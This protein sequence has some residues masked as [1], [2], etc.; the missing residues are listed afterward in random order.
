MGVRSELFDDDYLYFYSDVLGPQ[1]S[2]ADAALISELLSLRPG[3]RLLDA[4]CGE[5]RISGRLAALGCEVVG[6]D[7]SERFLA[8]ARHRHP[9][10]TFE[11]RDIRELG[12]EGEFDAAVNW[13]TSFGYF[14]PP[15]NDDVLAALA[16]GL[17]PGG[18]L[19]LE[20]H[21][22]WR[23]LRL[24]AVAG[25][26]AGIVVNRD[27]NVIADRIS[28]DEATRRSLTVALH[29]S[30]GRVRELEFSLEQVPA[31]ELVRRLRR[32]GFEHVD[33]RGDGGATFDPDS[34]R[35]IAI[36]Q[37]PGP[38]VAPERPVVSLR[39]VDAANVRAVCE[40][41]LAPGQSTYVAPAAY[42]LAEAQ[43]DE[44]AWVRVIY[45]GGEVVGLLA[46]I[47]DTDPPS[48]WLARLLVG[49]QHQHRGFGRAAIALL[50]E[51]VRSLPGARELE[52]SCVPGL[53]TPKGFYIGLGFEPTGEVR[54]GEELLTLKL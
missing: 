16:R 44:R 47:A 4:P 38:G 18:R 11:C 19:L 10:V 6:I 26:T 17:R 29:R 23:L 50:V 35:L 28:Y 51:H 30:D 31:P 14:D 49:A 12:Y 48:Y 2:D 15:T 36:A 33:L 3:M 32:A 40:L 20:L 39:E 5:G 46:L 24:L 27:A 25:G 42:T 21:N 43:H 34:R 54:G 7:A 41:E 13:F 52:T 37:R 45:A 1:R 22:P 53:A 8:I 9:G